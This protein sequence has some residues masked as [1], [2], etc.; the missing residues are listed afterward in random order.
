MT[1]LLN[2][3]RQ[4]FIACEWQYDVQPENHY[5]YSSVMQS[6]QK[7]AKVKAEAGLEEQAKILEL[8]GRAASMMLAP[9]SL[10]EAF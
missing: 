3:A 2:D 5:G 6:L 8:L 1:D 7:H 10:N 9:G 4:Q